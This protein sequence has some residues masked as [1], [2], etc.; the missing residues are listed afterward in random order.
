MAKMSIAECIRGKRK[1]EIHY[2]RFYLHIGTIT[3]LEHLVYARHSSKYFI[4]I[5]IFNIIA[6]LRR[7]MLLSLHFIDEKNEAYSESVI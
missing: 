4:C 3:F 5:H 1:E 7:L 6:K 2:T